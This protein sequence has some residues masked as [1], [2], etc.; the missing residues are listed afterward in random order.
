MQA[1]RQAD[2]VAQIHTN[3]SRTGPVVHDIW[4]EHKFCKYDLRPLT[5]RLTLV[6]ATIIFALVFL[7]AVYMCELFSYWG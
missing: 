5:L 6:L 3:N 2:C 4:C 7:I 1:G